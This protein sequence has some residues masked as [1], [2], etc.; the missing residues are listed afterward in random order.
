MGKTETVKVRV[1]AT[2]ANCGPGFD[3]LGIACNIYNELELT[4]FTDEILEISIS[5]EGKQYLPADE[6]NL[7]W[8]VIK[9]LLQKTNSPYKGARIKMHNNIPLS[10]GLGSSAA[11]IVAGI[12]AF[13]LAV[14]EPFSKNEMLKIATDVE[15]HPDNVAPA[16]FGGMTISLQEDTNVKTFS[17]IPKLPLKMIVAVPEFFLAT[18]KARQVLPEK[19]S[20]KDAAFN[21]AHASSLVAAMCT[22]NIDVLSYA[23]A[24]KLH[25]PYRAALIPGMYDVFSAARQAGALG[26][27]LSGAGP[28]LIAFT[29][30]NE[31][32]VGEA[33]VKAFAS[34]SIDSHYL[35]LDIDTQGASRI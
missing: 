3:A 11:A 4:L 27:A 30:D 24:D 10:H 5:G 26:A 29:L 31:T 19:I 8:N 22:G 25:Q 18:K 12:L 1:P 14:G 32:A 6:S 34:H 20:V 15:G 9:D 21:I 28:S 13:N 7:I 33:M 2:T 23:F 16:I 35:I 17:F